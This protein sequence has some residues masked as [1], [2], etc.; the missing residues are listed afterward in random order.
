MSYYKDK[1]LVQKLAEFGFGDVTEEF[2]KNLRIRTVILSK[3]QY[4][5]LLYYEGLGMMGSKVAQKYYT[6]LDSRNLSVNGLSRE[7]LVEILRGVQQPK[8]ERIYQSVE[9]QP[10]EG[11]SE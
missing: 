10:S 8:V 6:I 5:M 3:E 11:A 4:N 9:P 2:F 7:Q 1:G